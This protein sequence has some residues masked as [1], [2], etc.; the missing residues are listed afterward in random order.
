MKGWCEECGEETNLMNGCSG[1]GAIVCPECTPTH[2]CPDQD[3][4]DDE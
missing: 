1:C 3:D 4:E 2:L